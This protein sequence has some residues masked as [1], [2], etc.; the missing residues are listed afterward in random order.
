V[1]AYG[2]VPGE[3]GVKHF[4]AEVWSENPTMPPDSV[5]SDADFLRGDERTVS[6]GAAFDAAERTAVEYGLGEESLVAPRASLADPTVVVAGVVAP[7]VTGGAV[8]LN[9]STTGTLGVGPAGTVPETD[10]VD[11]ATVF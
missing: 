5:V 10:R 6:Q 4:E 2:D 7:L 9:E 8:L 1:L 11:P 3:T